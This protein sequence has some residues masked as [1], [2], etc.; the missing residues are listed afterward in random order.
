MRRMSAY[1]IGLLRDVT[2]GDDIVIE[3]SDLHSARA[4]YG[5]A[6]YRA[7]LTLRLRKAEGDVLL[8]DGVGR[9][10]RAT[11]VLRA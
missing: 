7:I 8:I 6:A 3:F 11:D 4:W 5:S 9:D 10:H 2:V 1:A